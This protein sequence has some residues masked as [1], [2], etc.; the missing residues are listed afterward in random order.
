MDIF[1]Q[2]KQIDTDPCRWLKQKPNMAL[3]M[4]ARPAS[5]KRLSVNS[6]PVPSASRIV[7]GRPLALRWAK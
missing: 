3:K 1:M 4:D 7:A 2:E 5:F 6:A